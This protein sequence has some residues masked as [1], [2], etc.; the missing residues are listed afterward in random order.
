[1]GITLNKLCSNAIIFNPKYQDQEDYKMNKSFNAGF[2]LIELMIVITI[3]SILAMI[4]VPSYNNS[5]SKARRSDGQASLMD[6]MA[7][8]ERFFTENNTYTTNLTGAAGLN[9][10]STSSQKSFY[11]ISAV[12]CGAGINSC[13]MLTA[14]AGSTQSADGDLTLDSIGI[15]LPANKW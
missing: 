15:K 6:V 1:M 13:V 4:A 12:A 10:A 5:V 2:T 7:R 11:T 8:Q 14:T 9:L 3:I